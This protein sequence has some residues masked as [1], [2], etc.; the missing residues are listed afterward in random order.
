MTAV[1]ITLRNTISADWDRGSIIVDKV[2]GGTVNLGDCVYLDDNNQVQQAIGSSSKAG[3]AYGIVTGLQNQYGETSVGLGGW[4]SVTVSGPVFGFIGSPDFI[5]GQM[6]YVSK[7]VAGG[8]DTAAPS[9]GVYDFIVGNAQAANT[10]FVRPGQTTPAS[11][12]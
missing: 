11:T 1:T 12:A 9:G 6:L 3:H 4:C 10:L 5:D 2:A 7:T 8:L